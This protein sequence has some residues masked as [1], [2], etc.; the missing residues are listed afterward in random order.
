[1]SA[2]LPGAGLDAPV[3]AALIGRQQHFAR[4]LGGASVF[5]ADVAPFAAVAD[6]SRA[7]DWRD[8]A[9]LLGPGALAV[10]VG[11]AP[12]PD[13]WH[14]EFAIRGRQMVA[15]AAAARADPEAVVLSGHDV[16]EMLDLVARTKPGPFG[17]RT[18]E[19]GTYLGVRVGGRLVAMAGERLSPPGAREISAV[20]THPDFRG[21]G[22]AARLVSS[23]VAG[24]VARGE[25]P[26]LHVVEDNVAAIGLYETL[27]FE[28]RRSIVF[29]G[30]VV[31]PSSTG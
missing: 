7:A 3:L 12:A 10:L 20:C 19:L 17:I 30:H 31:P 1:V 27:G 9:V 25:S 2:E 16:P 18:I 28:T 11:Q 22:L 24:I 15:S 13:D 23:L 14:R 8:L 21:R 6:P 5:E 29:T 26:I 4:T